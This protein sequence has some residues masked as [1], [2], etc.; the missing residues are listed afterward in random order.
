[1][2]AEASPADVLSSWASNATR[3]VPATPGDTCEDDASP[4]PAARIVVLKVT[5]CA[6]STTAMVCV[7][8]DANGT[9]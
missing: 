3:Y 7:A 9:G 2:K 1:M 5:A 8:V 6:V 4:T